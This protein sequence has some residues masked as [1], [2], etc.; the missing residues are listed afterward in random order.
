[1]TVYIAEIDKNGKR[2]FFSPKMEPIF[3]TTTIIIMVVVEII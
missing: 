2:S 1:M 3:S